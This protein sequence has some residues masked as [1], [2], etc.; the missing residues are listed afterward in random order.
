MGEEGGGEEATCSPSA[1]MEGRR[2]EATTRRPS[3]AEVVEALGLEGHVEG[4]YFARTYESDKNVST[5]SG[6]R[7]LM[8]SIYYLLTKESGI[9]HFHLNQSDI[10]HY[11]HKGNPIAYTLIH[12]DGSLEVLIMGSDILKG[13]KLQMMVRGGVW[14]TSRLLT[15]DDDYGLISEAVA[16]GFEYSDMTLARADALVDLFPQHSSVIRA[17]CSR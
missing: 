15:G 13:E 11:F 1:V 12:P 10:M 6:D 17:F 2:S 16:P 3:G 8:T 7:F 14:K 9:G 5:P 4:G